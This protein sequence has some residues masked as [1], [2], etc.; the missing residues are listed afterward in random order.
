M[1]GAFKR[2][3]RRVNYEEYGGVPLLGINGAAII[4]HGRS[5]PR[6]IHNAIRVA[7]EFVRN[8]VNERIRSELAPLADEPA[9]PTAP[10]GAGKEARLT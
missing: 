1:S 5:S 7:G 4:C 10:D 2:F 8:K 6:A 3:K 9:G